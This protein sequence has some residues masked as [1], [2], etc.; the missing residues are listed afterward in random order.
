MS[1]GQYS[2]CAASCAVSRVARAAGFSV[3]DD[4]NQQEGRIMSK[5]WKQGQ[6]KM[7]ACGTA[8]LPFNKDI[9]ECE[10]GSKWLVRMNGGFSLYDVE[11]DYIHPDIQR[12][13]WQ[14]IASWFN[15]A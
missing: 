11:T 14:V 4:N 15:N 5:T 2:A 6:E 7:W 10:D 3:S 8:N 12:A 9:I 1:A 13:G